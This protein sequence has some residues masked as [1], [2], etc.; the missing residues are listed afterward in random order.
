M[1]AGRSHVEESVYYRG[2]KF[3]EAEETFGI[4]IRHG[5][6]FKVMPRG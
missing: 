4:I 3:T 6:Y 2:D 5:F 1:I